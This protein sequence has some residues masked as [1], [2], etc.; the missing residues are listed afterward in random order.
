MASPCSSGRRKAQKKCALRGSLAAYNYR[1]RTPLTTESWV[2]FHE[3]WLSPSESEPLFERLQSQV[4]FEQRSVT[5]FGKVVAQPRLIGWCGTVAY[6][7]SGLTLPPRAAPECL[8]TVLH[9]VN[10]AA[11]TEFNHLLLNLYRNGDDSMGMH[12]DDEAELGSDPTVATL[13]LG[14]TRKFLLKARHGGH[15]LEYALGDGSLLIMGGRCQAEYVHGV[16]KTRAAVSPRLSITF[17][18]IVAPVR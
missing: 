8:T 16:P 1:M 12:A 18:R 2:D 7:Y 5:I 13:T 17:R 11:N 3:H 9:R 10:Q 6:R 4:A 14:A 15:R